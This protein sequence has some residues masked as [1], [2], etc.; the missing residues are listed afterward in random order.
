MNNFV[1]N[2]VLVVER[3]GDNFKYVLEDIYAG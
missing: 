1:K 3:L 2:T